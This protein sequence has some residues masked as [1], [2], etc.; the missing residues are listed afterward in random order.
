M[1]YFI[2]VLLIIIFSCNSGANNKQ[3]ASDTPEDSTQ[4]LQTVN[5]EAINLI[6]GYQVTDT[7][8]DYILFPLQVKDAKDKEESVTLYSKERGEGNMYWNIIFYNYKTG[9]NLLLEPEKKI[10]LGGYNLDGYSGNIYAKGKVE[11]HK[12]TP[13]IFYTVYTD[14]YNND[15]K[16]GTSDPAYFFVS[17]A[18]GSAFKQVSPP[19]IS[20]TQKSLP[21]NNSFLLLEGLKDSN[22]DKK[23]NENDEQVYYKVNMADSSLKT[24]EVFNSSFKIKL[25]KLFDK[26]WK[27][28]K[29]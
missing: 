28:L 15:K 24:E 29:D 17:N 4:I 11:T 10:L 18:D 25:K 6:G 23:F 20:I 27:K 14:D 19:N 9:E 8:N 16:L 13:Y 2:P 26:N 7:S 21:K 5:G 12:Q 1:K 22:N 3:V